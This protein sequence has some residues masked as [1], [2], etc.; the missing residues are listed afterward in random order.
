MGTR[1]CGLTR[2]GCGLLIITVPIVKRNTSVYCNTIQSISKW[3]EFLEDVIV[4]E[5][6]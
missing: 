2:G 1:V 6:L 5:E 3:L 4:N